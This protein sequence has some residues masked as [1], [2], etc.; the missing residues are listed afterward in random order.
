MKTC[1]IACLMTRL[2][3]CLM[4]CLPACLMMYLMTCLIMRL[5]TCL[6]HRR[7]AAVRALLENGA[8][9]DIQSESGWSAMMLAAN[10][11]QVDHMCVHTCM[12]A[13]RTC[14]RLSFGLVL[15]LLVQMLVGTRVCACVCASAQTRS[16][17]ICTHTPKIHGSEKAPTESLSRRLVAIP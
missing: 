3:M 1:L 9:P 2:I 15:S 14:V 16:L 12:R 10:N 5:M 4:T 13:G 17:W 6:M 8:S 11:W 7:H